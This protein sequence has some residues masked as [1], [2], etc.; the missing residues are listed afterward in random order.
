M[1]IKTEG[2]YKSCKMLGWEDKGS[3][4]KW[5]EALQVAPARECFVRGNIQNQSILLQDICNFLFMFICRSKKI[6]GPIISKSGKILSFLPDSVVNNSIPI[7]LYA[8]IS[9]QYKCFFY[10]CV[11]NIYPLEMFLPYNLK[12]RQSCRKYEEVY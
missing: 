5:E 2:I 12:D 3:H 4:W 1:T 6:K 9:S 11:K 10:S 8:W 7:F